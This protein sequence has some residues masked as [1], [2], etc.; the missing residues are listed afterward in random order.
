VISIIIINHCEDNLFMVHSIIIRAFNDPY[1]LSL[2]VRRALYYFFMYLFQLFSYIIFTQ[3]MLPMYNLFNNMIK[4]NR[5]E[6]EA[7]YDV[8][9]S[10]DKPDIIIDCNR[11]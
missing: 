5:Q 1:F 6:K 3:F 2:N 8:I 7:K 11:N 4:N 9:G 10:T